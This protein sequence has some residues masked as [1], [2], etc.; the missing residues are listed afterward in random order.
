FSAADVDHDLGVR[1]FCQLLLGDRLAAPERPG[2]CGSAAL[3]NREEAVEDT[4]TGDQRDRRVLLLHHGAG[5]TD[6]PA[7]D[8]R[9]LA[10]VFEDT[11]DLVDG[12]VTAPDGLDDACLYVGREHDLMDDIGLLHLAKD[13]A[14]FDLVAGFHERFECPLL[15]MGKTRRGDTTLDEI[16]HLVHKDGK[17]ALD[18]VIDTGEEPGAELDC[19]RETGVY[20]RLAGPDAR[21]ILVYLDNGILALDLDDLTHQRFF[22]DLDHIVH[23]GV[24]IDCRNYGAGDS[25]ENA[26]FSLFGFFG[27]HFHRSTP[28]DLLIFSLM[29]RPPSSPPRAITVGLTEFSSVARSRRGSRSISLLFRTRI[30]TCPSDRALVMHSLSFSSFSAV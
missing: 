5:D 2:D 19:K 14:R 28:T 27:F 15:L 6:R 22:S 10:A 17:R 21:C 20:D 24:K 1:P 8:H 7:L 4:L 29:D 23:V 16:S 9:V 25:F 3:C 11:D 26:L 18:T 30:P 12:E 13:C